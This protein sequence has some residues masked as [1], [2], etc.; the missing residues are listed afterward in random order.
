MTE[1]GIIFSPEM[2]RALLA[3]RKTQTRR[4]LYNGSFIKP[5]GAQPA[6][7]MEYDAE[8]PP[9]TIRPLGYAVTLSQWRKLK[10]GDRLYVREACRTETRGPGE[11]GI[12]YRADD[13]FEPIPQTT[14]ATQRWLKMHSYRGGSGQWLP[15]IHMPRWA[16]RI[17][18][19]VNRVKKE[20]LQS[21]TAGDA[22]AEGIYQ[23][24]GL[25]TV[26]DA[27]TQSQ[28]AG[29]NP[30]TAYGNLWDSLHHVAGERWRDNPPVVAITFYVRKGNIDA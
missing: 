21:I 5:G 15:N 9:P 19:L 4:L 12:R 14:E 17:T 30:R 20:K 27:F 22:I 16:S 29:I 23:D 2:V 25:W 28:K 6:P 26:S 18:L 7:R 8:F 24:D 10:A 1:K 13:H 11:R 3:E